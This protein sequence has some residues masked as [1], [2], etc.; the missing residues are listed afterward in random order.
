MKLAGSQTEQ[1]LLKS[2]AGES[3]A[4]QRYM[5][6]AKQARKEGYNYLA[7][8]FEDNANM[9]QVHAQ[10]FFSF[11]EGRPLQITATYPAGKVGTTIENVKA[12]IG[13]ETE[14]AE[15]AYPEFAKVA[16]SEG[17]PAIAALYEKIAVIEGQH[18]QRFKQVYNLL[19]NEQV[20]SMSEDTLWICMKCGYVHRGKNALKACPVCLEVNPFIPM[21]F[22]FY[23]MK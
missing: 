12:S 2:F 6:F 3:Q 9:E 5:M 17:F 8:I 23:N 22:N 7:N 21:N 11:L 18:A 15:E 13:G 4:Y 20:Y 16:K 14:E 1:N 19:A 10:R